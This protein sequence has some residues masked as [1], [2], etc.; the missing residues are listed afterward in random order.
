MIRTFF[1]ISGIKNK[2]AHLLKRKNLEGT[3]SK[4]LI[5]MV[6]VVGKTIN[7]FFLLLLSI[8]LYFLI[9]FN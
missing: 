4:C 7:S 6:S 9:V 5:E 2:K 1:L 8:S 3:L